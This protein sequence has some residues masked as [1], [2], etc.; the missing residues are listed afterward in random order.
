MDLTDILDQ[1]RQR[2]AAIND[3]I[4]ALE[5]AEAGKP[6]RGRPPKWI[7]AAKVP[8]AKRAAART[9]RARK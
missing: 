2:L 1:L 5:R 6:R 7:A 3:A 9:E 4:A 8:E